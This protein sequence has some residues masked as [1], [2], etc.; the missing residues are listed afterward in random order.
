MTRSVSAWS[1]YGLPLLVVLACVSTALALAAPPGATTT[2][3]LTFQQSSRQLL[4]HADPYFPFDPFR[5][6]NLNPPWVVTLM[7][8]LAL[9]PLPAAVVTWWAVSFACLAAT[10]GLIAKTRP[11]VPP[12]LAACLVLATQASYANLRLGQVAWPVMLLVTAAWRLDAKNRPSAAGAVLGVAAAW[13]PF[14][15]LF[16]V[17]LVWRR[18][19]RALLWM[20][21]TS[22]ALSA[23]GIL[24]V[25]AQHAR[26]W[27]HGMGLIYWEQLLLNASLRG[28]VARALSPS[29]IAELHTTPSV[30]APQAIP[31]MWIAL[32]AVVASITA[33]RIAAIGRRDHAWACVGLLSVVLSPLGWIHYVPIVIGPAIA[34][35]HSS[36]R[37]AR[38]LAMAGWLLLCVPYAWL[39]MRTF[40]AWSTLTFA[41]VYTWGVVL[42]LAGLWSVESSGRPAASAGRSSSPC[43]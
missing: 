12:V 32:A 34:S 13:K 22:V 26:T 41:S 31:L 7:A 36:R 6:P 4:E 40:G 18:E 19:R 8:P 20:A 25:G 27:L 11:E 35:L 14:L 37:S 2:D 38:A 21:A 24:A 10:V 29:P 15:F 33:W 3:F 23:A 5:G 43:C 28:V 9:L 30:L 39:R 1:A 17:Y 42:I 16:A